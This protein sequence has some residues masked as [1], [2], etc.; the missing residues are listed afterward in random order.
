MIIKIFFV[1]AMFSFVASGRQAAAWLAGKYNAAK[2]SSV[3]NRQRQTSAGS[4]M[5]GLLISSD[6]A[7]YWL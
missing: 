7:R 4:S 1:K 5:Y 6:T 3:N 2:V